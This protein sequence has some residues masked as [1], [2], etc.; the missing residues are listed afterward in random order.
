M[1]TINKFESRGWVK[2]VVMLLIAAVILFVLLNFGYFA[3]QLGFYTDKIFVT[4]QQRQVKLAE[5]HV[6]LAPDTVYIASLDIRAPIKYVEGKSES[7][8]QKALIDGVV[9]YP[10]TA[11]IGEKGNT[12][13]FGHSSDFAFSKGNYKTVFALLPNIEIGA[14]ISVANDQGKTFKYK[15]YKKFVAKKTDTQLLDQN[16][17]GKSILTLQTS[18]PVGTALQRYIVQAELVGE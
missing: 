4:D 12:Y 14:E 11:A 18:Y 6:E 13:I 5:D 15:V 3:K 9:Q 17:N 8:F 16:T 2:A 7:V 10:G 1:N